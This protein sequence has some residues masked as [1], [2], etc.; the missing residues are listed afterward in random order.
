MIKM[1]I[2]MFKRILW[3][4]HD[5]ITFYENVMTLIMKKEVFRVQNE[6]SIYL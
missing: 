5:L 3:I 2:F 4:F 1:K 6:F